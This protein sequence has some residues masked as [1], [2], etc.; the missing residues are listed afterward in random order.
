MTATLSA[1]AGDCLTMSD[2]TTTFSP[3]PQTAELVLV[4]QA[5]AGDRDAFGQ[6]VTRYAAMVTG[7][8][9]AILGDFARSEDAG[10]E[11]F[12]E[13][14]HKRDTLR[15]PGRFVAWVCQ[16]ARNRAIDLHRRTKRTTE[17]VATVDATTAAPDEAIVDTLAS[18]EQKE[19]VWSTLDQLPDETRET[20]VL[21]YRSGQSTAEVAAALDESESTIRK[22]L[23]RGRSMLREKIEML[24]GS[25]LQGTA[26]KATF[27][28][29]V[30]A[31]LPQNASAA[32]VAATAG[33]GAAKAAGGA[34]VAGA[35]KA[36]GALAGVGAAGL[37]GGA[38]GVLGGLLG[39]GLGLRATYKSSPY[40][41]QRRMWIGFGFVSLVWLV[42]FC[43]FVYDLVEQRTAGMLTPAE[44]QKQHML[45]MVGGQISLWSLIGLGLWLHRR[46][47]RREFIAQ[48]PTVPGYV[49]PVD[50]I[51]TAKQKGRGPYVRTSERVIFGLPLYELRFGD[52]VVNEFGEARPRTARGWIAIGDRAI[53]GLFACGGVALGPISVG[54]LAIGGLS[55]GGGAIGA[56]ALGGGALGL[57]AIGGGAFGLVALGG[58]VIAAVGGGSGGLSLY[59][60]GFRN[61]IVAKYGTLAEGSEAGGFLGFLCDALSL[62]TSG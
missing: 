22:R 62:V 36:G 38:L 11:A 44:Q 42:A 53:G 3:D 40:A 31:G 15:E 14:W 49:N 7:V 54:G 48:T 28:A 26:P 52:V 35:A 29:V 41:A 10:Q 20:M 51:E 8:A 45:I 6:L 59:G 17:A 4:G 1:P 43:W 61:E 30:L 37:I 32:V 56:V 60:T 55:I 5:L 18:D 57:L 16:I 2:A 47:Q 12:I 58:G 50:R 21:F 13:A 33:S 19:L 9:Y 23:S 27:A 46:I 34:K 24:V 25:T 39:A